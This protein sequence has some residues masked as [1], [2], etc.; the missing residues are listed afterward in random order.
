M[1]VPDRCH[2]QG[3]QRLRRDGQRRSERVAC[4]AAMAMI[5]LPIGSHTPAEIALSLMSEIVAIKS[6]VQLR[7]K[8]PV[9]EGV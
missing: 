8:K 9:Q 4:G 3:W 1:N 5:G 7:Q 2:L 6:G